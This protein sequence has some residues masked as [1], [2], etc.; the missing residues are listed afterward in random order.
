MVRA[1]ARKP[2]DM[3]SQKA[4]KSIGRGADDQQLGAQKFTARYCL[5]FF[6]YT[7]QSVFQSYL[8]GIL[9]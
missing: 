7:H 5:C 9:L 6:D 3:K 8:Q 1:A 4:G 2:E